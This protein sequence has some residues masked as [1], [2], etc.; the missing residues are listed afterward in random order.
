LLLLPSL[1]FALLGA[2][3]TGI[4]PALLHA[5]H[6]S[7]YS[8]ATAHLPDGR[9]MTVTL[10]NEG[11][12]VYS[13][14]RGLSWAMLSGLGLE[15]QTPWEVTYHPGLPA[16]G[17]A[18]LFLI[19][20]EGGVWTWDPMADVVG[21]LNSGIPGNDLHILDLESPLAGSDG[22]VMALSIR[23][24]VYL[25]WPQTM[26][27]QL[28]HQMPGVYGRLGCVALNPH[29]DSTSAAL[30]AQDMFVGAS[31]L[32]YV[33]DDG[34]QNWTLHP[35]F[36]IQAVSQM[37]WSIASLAISENYAVDRLILMG[38]VH[39]ENSYGGDFGE[40][41][42]SA[43][44]GQNFSRVTTLNSGILNLICTPP[45]P[46]GARSWIACTRA[47]PNTGAYVGIGIIS[48][49]DG[50]LTWNHYNNHQDFL[51][52]QNPGKVSG[53]APLNYELQ[54]AV[55]PDYGTTGEVWYGR[56]EGLFIST[57]EGV[58]WRQ[59]QMRVEREFRDLD[60]SFTTDGR[61]AVFGAGYGVGTVVHIPANGLVM[62]LPEQPPM[63]YQRRLDVSPNFVGDGNVIVAGNVTLWGWQ[64]RQVPIA[65]PLN[66]SFWW[67]PRNRDPI[68]QQNLTGFPRVVA[69]SPNF[70]G[71]GLPGT[72]Q[73]YFWCGWDFGPYRS[74]DNGLTAKA[75]HDLV[76]G[77]TVGE[78]TCFAIAPTYDAAGA[79]TDAYTADAGGK[80]YRLVNEQ[81]LQLADLGPLVEDIVIAPDWS[82][83]GNPS[84]FAAL[85]G[86]P[87]V[88][89]IVDDP[90]NFQVLN[91]GVGLP[92]VYANGLACHPDF[93]NHPV[94]YLS[95]FGSGVWKLDMSVG[96]PVWERVGANFP[97]LWCRDVA[98]SA[99]FENDKFVY[100]ATQEGIWTVR[101]QPGANWGQLT[102]QG[103][104][105]DTDESFQYF[106]PNDP[107]NPAPDHA[108]PW[109]EAKRWAL[110]HPVVVFGESLSFTTYD[111]SYANTAAECSEFSVMTV[112]GPGTGRLLIVAQ[113]FDTGVTVASSS[114]DLRPLYTSPKAHSVK[115]Q[116]G[117][118]RKVRITV[119]ADLDPGEALILDGIHFKD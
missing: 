2:S 18:G 94:L 114:T 72:D 54:L 57:D 68:T 64:S 52:E 88:V 84:L 117:S 93:A 23:G 110:P 27:W 73:T 69:Y 92:E 26:T 32:F 51:M 59:R 85:A 40:I 113:D 112:A 5:P 50:G 1:L 17:G 39:Y 109:N 63:I 108:W 101:D 82:R 7:V 107:S 42:R 70:D 58:H 119:T 103:S 46:G 105:D 77:G 116:L 78:M 65:N 104:R 11:A 38:R 33:S 19:G 34:G 37:E 55:M 75:L 67:E 60:T 20:T 106:Q 29:F 14:D 86:A 99:D 47:Y 48:S 25:L 98:L 62:G 10:G 16:A 9:I 6:D 91:V 49:L 3:G 44:R 21:V 76:G 31:G 115:L 45:G 74:E 22:P 36:T 43:N 15:L 56:Q 79:R 61:K 118:F 111:D 81:W 4:S 95:T 97:R 66:K 13:T 87:Y 53:Y 35:Q 100:A 12:V 90:G 80:L 71:R 102:T 41:L 89:K 96:S 8:I 83:P 24:G 28:T 30:G